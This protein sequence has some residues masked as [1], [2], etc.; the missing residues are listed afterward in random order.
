MLTADRL[1][2]DGEKV[3]VFQGDTDTIPVGGGTGG[4]RSLYSEGQAILRPQMKAMQRGGEDIR[5]R[6]GF[7][8]IVRG[9]LFFDQVFDMRNAFVRF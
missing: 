9:G 7:R 3:R 6:L 2:I 8:S 4:A 5:M 1:G